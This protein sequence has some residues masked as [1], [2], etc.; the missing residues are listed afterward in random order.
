KGVLRTVLMLIVPVLLLLG[1]GYYWLASGG[2]VSTDD[3]QVKQDIVSVSPQ[4]NGQI[5]QVLVRN[6]ARVTR[7]QLLFRID[8]QPYRVALE[9]AEAQLAAA[10]LQTTQLRTQATGT[11]GDIVGSQANLEIKQNAFARQQALLNQGFTTRAEYE[12]TL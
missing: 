5:V 10:R 2:K 12:D 8:P 4:V 11:G 6:G 1:G 7:G 3:A 9:Q